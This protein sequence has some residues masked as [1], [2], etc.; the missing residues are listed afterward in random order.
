VPNVSVH[1]VY[2]IDLDQLWKE[3]FRGII[4]DLDNTLVGAKVAEATPE[5]I[6]WLDTVQQ[7]GFRVVIVSNNYHSRVSAF[8]NPLQIPFIH[9]AKKPTAV[10]FRKAL[11]VLGTSAAETV[12]IGDQLMTDVL[13]GNRFG[14]HTILVKPVAL[15]EEGIA[16]KL[17]NR[18]LE[19]IAKRLLRMKRS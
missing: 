4:T 7:K 1:S 6:Q 17:I 19:R 2:E 12:V 10:P 14:L 9:S 13:G 5:L 15:H 18:P 11:N 3:G 8:A 16:T